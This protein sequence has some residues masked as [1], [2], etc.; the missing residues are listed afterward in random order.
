MDSKAVGFIFFVFVSALGEQLP[1]ILHVC[2]FVITYDSKNV[3]FL[4]I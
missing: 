3:F 2:S 4:R 1:T